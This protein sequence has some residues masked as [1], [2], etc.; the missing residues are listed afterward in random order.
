MDPRIN[1]R[2]LSAS[3]GFGGSCLKKDVLALVYIC[4]SYQL[5]EV[6]EYWKSV[7]Q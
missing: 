4:E 3:V 5:H 1:N 6:A 2:Y 7:C